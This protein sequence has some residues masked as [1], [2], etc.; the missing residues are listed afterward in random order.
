MGASDSMV[1]SGSTE[2]QEV[3]NKASSTG[4]LPMLR[5]AF[6]KLVD[7]ET[8]A[9]LAILLI[10]VYKCQSDSS[11]IPKMFPD[12]CI[13]VTERASQSIAFNFRKGQCAYQQ[14]KIEEER[15]LEQ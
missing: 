6:S 11:N 13:Y 10:L 2:K 8:N 4:A 12:A 14:M 15:D 7:P 5:R 3:E 9:V 1:Q